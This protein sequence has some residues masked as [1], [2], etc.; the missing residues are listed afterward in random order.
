MRPVTLSLQQHEG[1]TWKV[2][3]EAKASRSGGIALSYAA[4]SAAGVLSLRVEVS[5]RGHRLGVFEYGHVTVDSRPQ[6]LSAPAPTCPTGDTGS[7]PNCQTPAPNPDQGARLLSGQTLDAGSYLESPN[8]NYQLIMQ[9]DGNLVLYQGSTAL[10]SSGTAGDD[11]AFV[12]MQSDGNLVI[13]DNGV[14][15]WNSNTAGF[16]GDYL[17]LQDDDNLVIY[18]ATD[19]I[20]DWASGYMGDRLFDGET[21][22]AGEELISPGRGYDLIMQ[23]DGNLVLYQGSTALWSSGTYGD[24]G[25]F[26]AMQSD[27]NLVIYDNGVAEWS[28]NTAGFSGDYLELQDDDNLVIYQGTDPIWDWASGYM[29]DRLFGGETLTA[30][31]ELVSPGHAYQLIMQGDGNLVL[32]QGSTAL[33][34]SS[35]AGDTGSYMVMQSDGNLVVY[36]NGVAEWNS[37]TAGFPGDF[38]QLQDDNNLVIYQGSTAIWDWASGQLG[39]SAPGTGPGLAAISWTQGHLG[40]SYDDGYCLEFVQSAYTAAGVSIGSADT[41]AGYWSEN[42]E[43]YTEHPGNTNPPVGAL[44]FW[45]PDDVDG[46]SNP[47]GHVGIYVGAVPGYGSDEVISTWSWPEPSDQPDVH[48]FSLSGRNSAGYPYLGW[49]APA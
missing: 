8:G 24:D 31:E 22:T 11:G 26:L 34:S 30:G 5:R 14:A 19:P 28:S 42:P 36:D 15:E 45:G 41:A 23:G 43:G 17:Q 40:T 37:N 29:G 44:V 13:Y 49:M 16:A 12:A 6:T 18:Q 48:Y 20:W 7:P 47:A 35:T 46:Y 38:L 10:W 3:A 9:G 1:T 33:W 21:L 2:R 39:G 4:P 27:G 32:Y 25:A